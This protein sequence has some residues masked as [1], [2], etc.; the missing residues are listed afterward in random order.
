MSS[1]PVHTIEGPTYR[2]LAR[3]NDRPW[4][5]AIDVEL[6]RLDDTSLGDISFVCHPEF[7]EFAFCQGRTTEELVAVVA[8][9]LESAVAE[10]AQAWAAGLHVYALFNGTVAAQPGG[11]SDR[12]EDRP[13]G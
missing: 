6:Y 4:G 2:A 3:R 5:H 12:C 10:H 7:D 1:P 8:E 11:P 13:R 9:R